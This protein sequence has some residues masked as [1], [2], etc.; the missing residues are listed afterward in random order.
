M[1][2]LRLKNWASS[3][4]TVK[5][6]S[7][8]VWNFR[9]RDKESLLERHKDHFVFALPSGIKGSSDFVRVMRERGSR[10]TDKLVTIVVLAKFEMMSTPTQLIADG[11]R[12]P[13]PVGIDTHLELLRNY[14]GDEVVPCMYER[15][16]REIGRPSAGYVR[17]ARP[18]KSVSSSRQARNLKRGRLRFLMQ[19]AWNFA[20]AEFT[21]G[22]CRPTNVL[23]K[24]ARHREP[25][26]LSPSINRTPGFRGGGGVKLCNLSVYQ[27]QKWPTQTRLW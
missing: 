11:H 24:Y 13:P 5:T 8:E 18:W 16:P 7:L 12:I 10:I 1:G 6:Y 4:A 14:E 20:D 27:S 21:E 3:A 15:C 26:S 19:S 17:V 23:M 22:W 25:R 9:L 2:N